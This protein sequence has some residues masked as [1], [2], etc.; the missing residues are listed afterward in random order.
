MPL[1]FCCHAVH[2][3][4]MYLA[5]LVAVIN[6][7]RGVLGVIYRVQGMNDVNDSAD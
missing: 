4:S 3:V 5:Q 6:R 1:V 2:T 7:D